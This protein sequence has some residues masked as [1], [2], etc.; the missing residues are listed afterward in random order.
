MKTVSDFYK[1]LKENGLYFDRENKEWPEIQNI[2]KDNLPNLKTHKFLGQDG[3]PL[4]S[5]NNKDYPY[6]TTYRYIYS[7]RTS[8][9]V[10]GGAFSKKKLITA[11]DLKAF[12]NLAKTK[13]AHIKK[14]YIT[15]IEWS[16]GDKLIDGKYTTK[17]GG[18]YCLHD[19]EKQIEKINAEIKNLQDRKRR[20]QTISK[21]IEK[22]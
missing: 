10:A 13:P 22:A 9:S 14:Q 21:R 18:E 11:E 19:C 5:L 1:H 7:S 20:F 12:F 8:N 15:H 4:Y 3:V 6:W 2:L 16:D 17:E